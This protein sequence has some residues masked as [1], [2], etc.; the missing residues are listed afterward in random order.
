MQKYVKTSPR[1]MWRK[2]RGRGGFMAVMHWNEMPGRLMGSICLQ[3]LSKLYSARSLNSKRGC[4][5]NFIMEM[6]RNCQ[7]PHNSDEIRIWIISYRLGWK[8]NMDVERRVQHQSSEINW[9]WPYEI[10]LPN[11][12]PTLKNT[13]VILKVN[14]LTAKPQRAW[15]VKL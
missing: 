6:S 13:L 15:N 1:W 2:E 4:R 11:V 3:G 12:S 9:T 14:Q 10:T 7:A 5:R 8:L